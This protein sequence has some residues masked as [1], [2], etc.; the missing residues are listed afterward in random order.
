[1]SDDVHIHPNQ[2]E[3]GVVEKTIMFGNILEEL[4]TYCRGY[5]KKYER[6]ENGQVIIIREKI[7]QKPLLNEDGVM[8]LMREAKLRFHAKFMT[9]ELPENRIKDMA[10]ELGEVLTDILTFKGKDFEIDPQYRSS[11][12][13]MFCNNFEAA[14]YHSRHGKLQDNIYGSTHIK[15]EM[16]NQKTPPLFATNTRG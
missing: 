10:R 4:E 3:L 1:M 8:A 5:W 16:E 12:V 11:I 2:P 14:L 15:Q 7:S 6:D 9:T 13:W